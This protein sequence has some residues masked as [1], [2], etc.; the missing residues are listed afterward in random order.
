MLVE[1]VLYLSIDVEKKEAGHF[2]HRGKAEPRPT[3]H[4]LGLDG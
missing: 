3:P 2:S 1:L 4:L